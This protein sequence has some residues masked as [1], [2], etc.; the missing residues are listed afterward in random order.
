MPNEEAD[1]PPV[2][3]LIA[4]RVNIG[5]SDGLRRS[6][7]I[8]LTETSEAGT[9]FLKD[10]CVMQELLLLPGTRHV[11]AI[12]LVHEARIAEVFPKTISKFRGPRP[13]DLQS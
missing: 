1:G 8:T 12:A 6:I 4:T 10:S 5:S 9:K 11:L 13:F 2:S 7:E 3:F